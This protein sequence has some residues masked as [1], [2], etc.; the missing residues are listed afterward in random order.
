MREQKFS[1][2][3]CWY[4]GKIRMRLAAGGAPVSVRRRAVEAVNKVKLLPVQ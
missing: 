3:A 1:R 2:Q 4:N